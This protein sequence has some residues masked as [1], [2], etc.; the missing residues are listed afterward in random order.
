MRSYMPI[1]LEIFLDQCATATTSCIPRGGGVNICFQALTERGF[2]T[3]YQAIG[4]PKHLQGAVRLDALQ[5]PGPLCLFSTHEKEIA[6]VHT[7]IRSLE[8]EL[9]INAVPADHLIAGQEL[10]DRL[11][12]CTRIW[13][14][15]FPP[16]ID[17]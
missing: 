1:L 8:E 17:T 9:T 12:K 6:A 16:K 5:A 15:R 3:E 7:L 2:T 11:S 4:A 13:V 10:S 14:E